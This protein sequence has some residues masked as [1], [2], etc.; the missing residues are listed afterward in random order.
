MQ[1]KKYVKSWIKAHKKEL[2]VA[3]IT[4]TGLLLL[5]VGIENKEELTK[6]F[7]IIEDRINVGKNNTSVM[8]INAEKTSNIVS[9]EPYLNNTRAP[10]YVEGHPMK[11]AAGKKISEEMLE[12]VKE[13]NI[14]LPPNYTFR[15][16]YETGAV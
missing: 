2:V 11:L 16:S 9:I 6:L 5:V 10:H 7:C 12:F 3:G 1:E 8:Q 15:R 14:E 4:I 13:N